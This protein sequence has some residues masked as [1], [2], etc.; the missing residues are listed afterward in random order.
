MSKNSSAAADVCMGLAN[1]HDAFLQASLVRAQME[2]SPPSANPQEF[3]ISDRGRFERLWVA[4]LY[5]LVEAWG[6]RQMSQVRENI[7]AITSLAGLEQILN[8]GIVNGQISSMGEV[9]HYVCHRD[10][11]KYWDVG[12]LSV[13]GNLAY[14]Q[15]LHD[16]F[17]KVLMAA[18]RE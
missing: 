15:R 16:A 10:K 5:V 17:S 9:R 4:L 13:I 14:H 18:M 12:R 3:L 1:L 8:E 7:R 6:S 2:Q 11:R